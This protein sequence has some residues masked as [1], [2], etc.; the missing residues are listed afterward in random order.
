MSRFADIVAKYETGQYARYELRVRADLIHDEAESEHSP[1]WRHYN[2]VELWSD[3]AHKFLA[4]L[5]T[6]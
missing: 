4:F 5:K 6:L 2:T 1:D 3:D